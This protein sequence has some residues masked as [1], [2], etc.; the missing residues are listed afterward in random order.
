VCWP[1]LPDGWDVHIGDDGNPSGDFI[2]HNPDGSTERLHPDLGDSS[3]GPHWDYGKYSPGPTGNKGSRIYPK[4][5]DPG[6][7]IEWTS[8]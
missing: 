4:P 8:K 5:N 2:K 6:G 3:R 7:W 1:A